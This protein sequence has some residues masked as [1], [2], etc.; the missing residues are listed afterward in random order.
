[1]NK[2]VIDRV[3]TIFHLIDGHYLD[4]VLG[5]LIFDA[6]WLWLFL[7][8]RSSQSSQMC[9]CFAWEESPS[10][11][12]VIVTVLSDRWHTMYRALLTFL[13][14]VMSGQYVETDSTE[15]VLSDLSRRYP[16]DCADPPGAAAESVFPVPGISPGRGTG[17]LREP[18]QAA[19]SDQV[20]SPE[21]NCLLGWFFQRLLHLSMRIYSR[22][23]L[24]CE[25]K[26]SEVRH[27]E[28]WPS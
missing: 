7:I 28:W 14:Q 15:R 26:S 5:I 16:A 21:E 17:G 24:L 22:L 8:L 12:S 4:L 20:R 13:V 27:L 6:W 2:N 3:T 18:G 11:S 19:V 23:Q 9:Y 25:T 1:M 10:P